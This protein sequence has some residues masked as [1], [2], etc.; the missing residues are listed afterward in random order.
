[1]ILLC[2]NDLSKVDFDND[3]LAECPKCGAVLAILPIVMR[4]GCDHQPR[5]RNGRY[6]WGTRLIPYQFCSLEC[7]EEA[8][9]S[10]PRGLVNLGLQ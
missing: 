10:Y 5:P 1:M 6:R 4:F 2:P 9:Q 3:G 7:Q 8:E